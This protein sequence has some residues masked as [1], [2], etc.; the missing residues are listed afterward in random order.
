MP[1]PQGSLN[2]KGKQSVEERKAR[3]NETRKA[4]SA[5]CRSRE[6]A[7]KKVERRQQKIANLSQKIK[8]SRQAL[9][10]VGRFTNPTDPEYVQMHRL[11][12]G[13]MEDK[14]DFIREHSG[15]ELA[16]DSDVAH[17]NR[18]L[19][20]VFNC[21]LSHRA[22]GCKKK[23]LPAYVQKELQQC[24]LDAES[25]TKDTLRQFFRR[26]FREEVFFPRKLSQPQ[27]ESM[28]SQL[29][30]DLLRLYDLW[31]AY[32]LDSRGFYLPVQRYKDIIIL[33]K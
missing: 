15:I 29:S 7:K 19:M 2:K 28:S 25:V 30:G 27:D 1:R 17:V 3:R 18:M 5:E 4:T 24:A 23:T 22:K 12:Q 8:D 13:E 9:H 10:Q 16:N 11:I 32:L 21:D 33:W 14:I 20:F 26:L 6:Y 31:K